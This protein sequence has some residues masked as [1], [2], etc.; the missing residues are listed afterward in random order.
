MGDTTD[1]DSDIM[2]WQDGTR[3]KKVRNDQS[4]AWRRAIWTKKLMA[5]KTSEKKDEQTDWKVMI[6]YKKEE[7]H[8]HPLK[9]TKA[10]E[11]E[12]GKIKFAKYLSNKRLLI[13]AKDQ[14]HT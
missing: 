3:K 12:M 8:F 6:T 4:P 10:I 1:G 5:S 14:L 2:V 11:K 9:L 13:L 7:G